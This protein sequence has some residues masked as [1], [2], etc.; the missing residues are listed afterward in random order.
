MFCYRPKQ[1]TI[2]TKGNPPISIMMFKITTNQ[3]KLN[4]YQWI[5]HLVEHSI[6]S[7]NAEERL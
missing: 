6:I 7:M 4:R 5:T 1:N 2:L 3:Y